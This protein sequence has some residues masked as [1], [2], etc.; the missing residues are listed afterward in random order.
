[1]NSSNVNPVVIL[2]AGPI[3]LA[4]ASHL[5]KQ[6]IPF[7]VLEKGSR[8]GSTMLEWGHVQLFSPWSYVVDAIS[9]ELLQSMD[10]KEPDRDEY[11]TGKDVVEQYLEPLAALPE[12]EKNLIL[13]A[14]VVSVSRSGLDK[15]K[16]A[17]REQSLFEIHYMKEGF[18]HS[19]KG[20]AVIDATGTWSSPNPVRSSQVW[21]P[22]ELALQDRISYNIPNREIDQQKYSNKH[23]AVVGSGHSAI[24]TISEL[25]ALPNTQITWIIRKK[26]VNEVYGGEQNDQLSKRGELGT[27]AKSFIESGQV[28]VVTDFRVNRIT[29]ETN[30]KIT[31][32]SDQETS[33]HDVD[34]VVANTGF[35]PSFEFLKE[36]RLGLE[37]GTESP[38]QLAPLIDPNLHSCGTVRPHGEAVLRHPEKDFYIAGMKSYGRAPTFLLLTGYEQIRSIVA[39]LAGDTESAQKVSLVLPETGVCSVSRVKN[40]VSSGCCS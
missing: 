39:H 34:F 14:E 37:P 29:E 16:N 20:Q 36:I 22:D 19:L 5:S 21:L 13:H 1:M 10:W 28:K 23:V 35:R 7:V 18:L 38:V 12:I 25:I 4:A 33:V 27:L 3:G 11:P 15:M 32:W 6:D 17:N 40:V 31:I 9:R 8:V 24:Q 30:G 26:S 2:G